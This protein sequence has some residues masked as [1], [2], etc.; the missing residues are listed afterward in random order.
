MTHPEWKA[1]DL[2]LPS[3]A[4]GKKRVDDGKNLGICVA[5]RLRPRIGKELG[6]GRNL[7]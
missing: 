4:R 6:I 5:G 7:R 2:H 1:I 3:K